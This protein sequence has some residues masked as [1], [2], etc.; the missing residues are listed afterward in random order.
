M[1]DRILF[2]RNNEIKFDKFSSVS[3]SDFEEAHRQNKLNDVQK[4]LADAL[5][6]YYD[7]N[8]RDN[9]KDGAIDREELNLMMY[10]LNDY[11]KDGNLGKREA[12]KF[13]KNVLGAE[14]KRDD[15]EA[16]MKY[17]ATKEDAVEQVTPD[18]VV[19]EPQNIQENET[20]LEVNNQIEEEQAPPQEQP[21]ESATKPYSVKRNEVWYDIVKSKYEVDEHGTVMN[22]VHQLK[23]VAGVDKNDRVMP[24]TIELLR[25]VRVNDDVYTLKEENES[26]VQVTSRI[27]HDSNPPSTTERNTHVLDNIRTRGNNIT[28][29]IRDID[30]RVR[31]RFEKNNNGV[32]VGYREYEYDTRGNQTREISRSRD[33]ALIEYRERSYDD[34]N[35]EIRTV[36]RNAQGEAQAVRTIEYDE[37][38][39]ATEILRDMDGNEI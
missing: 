31:Y 33:G 19:E 6:N 20:P 21:A 28:P 1:V 29:V 34:S 11:S 38:G 10:M 16:V 36:Y 37:Q 17:M 8:K 15:L 27:A 3:W 13:F 26:Q 18:E 12:S 32:L 4:R 23:D 22:I 2:G 9:P 30:G 24:S 5:V 25:E 35:R 39:R 14:F 7:R